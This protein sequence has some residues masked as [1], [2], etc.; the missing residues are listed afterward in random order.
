MTRAL[1]LALALACLLAVTA[2]PAVA[3]SLRQAS[4]ASAYASA[5]ATG[6][7]SASARAQAGEQGARGRG[8]HVAR[9]N[10]LAA[11]CLPP[12]PSGA[13]LDRLHSW[14][15]PFCS[16]WRAL[17]SCCRPWP[18]PRRAPTRRRRPPLSLPRCC[19]HRPPP[20]LRPPPILLPSH[21]PVPMTTCRQPRS[22]PAS[23]RRRGASVSATRVLNEGVKERAAAAN[24]CPVGIAVPFPLLFLPSSSALHDPAGA[25]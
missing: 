25:L 5:S 15:A 9:L 1:P 3:R 8:R 20:R 24:S 23:S 22:T 21:P 17:R 12:Q 19:P 2:S 11:G 7:T 18:R 16:Q 6:A 4:T 14:L 13:L 10:G